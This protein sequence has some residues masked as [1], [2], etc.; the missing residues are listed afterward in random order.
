MCFFMIALVWVVTAEVY[1]VPLPMP[2]LHPA[3]VF[4]RRTTLLELFN[5]WGGQGCDDSVPV[6]VTKTAPSGVRTA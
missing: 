1:N 2:L 4:H 6:E 3:T 5:D